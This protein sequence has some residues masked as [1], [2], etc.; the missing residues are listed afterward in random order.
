[1]KPS[2][3]DFPHSETPSKI[4]DSY[5]FVY[6]LEQCVTMGDRIVPKARLTHFYS[7]RS[8]KRIEIMLWATGLP[9]EVYKHSPAGTVEQIQTTARI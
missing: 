2:I 3:N 9:F 1:M 5:S 8:A 6:M 4:G 7:L